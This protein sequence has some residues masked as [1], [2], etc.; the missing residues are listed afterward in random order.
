MMKRVGVVVGLLWA[1]LGCTTSP[2]DGQSVENGSVQ[3]RGFAIEPNAAMTIQILDPKTGSWVVPMG[4]EGSIR[5]STT[6]THFK[7][8]VYAWDIGLNFAA[9]CFDAKGS[10]RVRV[11]E[12]VGD[13]QMATYMYDEAGLTCLFTRLGSSPSTFDAHANAADCSKGRTEVTLHAAG[14]PRPSSMSCAWSFGAP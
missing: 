14:K 6:P 2:Y 5:A 1:S 4:L 13:R 10:A 8:D 7:Q 9:P 3:F 12:K 11:F